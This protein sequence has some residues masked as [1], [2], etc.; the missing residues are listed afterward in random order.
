MQA[1]QG[2]CRDC[3][4]YYSADWLHYQ[5]CQAPIPCPFCGQKH[6]M[7]PLCRAEPEEWKQDER[8]K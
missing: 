7:L 4:E 1:Q 6:P 3:G 2:R 5:E 8:R